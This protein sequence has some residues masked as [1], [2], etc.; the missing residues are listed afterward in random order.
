MA[1]YDSAEVTDRERLTAKH[2]RQLAAANV[3][4]TRRQLAQQ[5]ENYDFANRQNRA[6]ADV[7][8]QQNSRKT[9]ADRFE[10]QRDL[11]N[12]TLGL[13]GSMGNAMNGSSTGNLMR[14]LENRNDKEN[15]TYWAQHQVN[16]D[17]VENSYN[18]S[19]NQNNVAK[20]EAAANAQKALADIQNDLAANLNNIN[21]SLYIEPG[22]DGTQY[23]AGTYDDNK[24]AEN[25]ARIS[26]YL[27]PDNRNG[28]IRNRANNNDYFSRLLNG[29]NGR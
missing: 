29:F 16:Q 6:L 18:D 21:P 23:A 25:N 17:Q 9:S 5:L 7:Q 20:N 4:S 28:A 3:D 15:N 2:Q 26:G 1:D 27:M 14:M 8:L 22:T 19:L 10:A 13:L 24:V 12:A 11:Q